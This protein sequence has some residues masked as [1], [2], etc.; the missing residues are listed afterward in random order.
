M[1]MCEMIRSE[2]KLNQG[3]KRLCHD[4]FLSYISKSLIAKIDIH[5]NRLKDKLLNNMLKISQYNSQL[6]HKLI[7]SIYLDSLQCKREQKP[8]HNYLISMSII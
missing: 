3:L 7:I 6:N 5:F 2:M 1:K 8:I 4:L